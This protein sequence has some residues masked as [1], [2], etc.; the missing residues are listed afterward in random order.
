MSIF[1]RKNSLLGTAFVLLIIL[2]FSCKSTY[3]LGQKR[4][5]GMSDNK[6]YNYVQDSSLMYKNPL[7]ET[8]LGPLRIKREISEY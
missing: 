6:L 4:A 5:R 3:E 8:F 7:G 2:Q 1:Q